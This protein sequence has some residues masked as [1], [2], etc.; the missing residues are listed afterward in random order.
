MLKKLQGFSIL[1]AGYSVISSEFSCIEKSSLPPDFWT[2][3]ASSHYGEQPNSIFRNGHVPGSTYVINYNRKDSILTVSFDCLGQFEFR[4]FVYSE[5]FEILN[6]RQLRVQQKKL[7]SC[8]A[9]KPQIGSF[10]IIATNC[11]SFLIIGSRRETTRYVW[12]L[13]R[14]RNGLEPSTNSLVRF[15]IEDDLEF[16]QVQQAFTNVSSL[17]NLKFFALKTKPNAEIRVKYCQFVLVEKI[18]RENI[19]ENEMK[20]S[21]KN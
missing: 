12:I 20:I 16:V 10:E 7:K 21:R 14:L 3:S 13:E 17:G 5:S 1:V 18:L 15:H 2:L 4:K 11:E 9:R 8:G 6:T 19:C